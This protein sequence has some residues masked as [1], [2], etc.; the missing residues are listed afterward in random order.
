MT[1]ESFKIS[2]IGNDLAQWPELDF[3]S[4]EGLQRIAKFVLSE[5]ALAERRARASL[6]WIVKIK[7]SVMLLTDN[8]GTKMKETILNDLDLIITANS[9]PVREGA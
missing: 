6:E 4:K 2:K 9:E 1:T 5:V 7:H 8:T 3:V